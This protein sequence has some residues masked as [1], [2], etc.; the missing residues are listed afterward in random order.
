M[1]LEDAVV[2]LLL[3]LGV[4]LEVIACLGLVAMRDV[5]DRLHYVAP[6]VFGA[7]LVAAAVWAREGPSMIGLKAALLAA[8]LLAASPALAHG[9]ARATRI[10]RLGDWRAQRG[11]GIE[12]EDR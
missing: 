11:E 8:F 2:Y 4:A 3:G 9:T 7:V 1:S 5:H 6:S 12:V 10:S